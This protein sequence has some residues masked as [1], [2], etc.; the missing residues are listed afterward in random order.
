MNLQQLYFFKE[1]AETRHFTQAAQNLY[2]VQSTLS[3]AIQDLERELGAPL[4][5]RNANKRIELSTY[6][7]AFL[8]YVNQAIS[9]IEEGTDTVKEMLNPRSGVVKIGFSFLNGFALLPKVVNELYEEIDQNEISI[10]IITNTSTLR[11]ESR[12][13]R[14][15]FDLAITCHGGN[16]E[17]ES[18]FIAAQRLM[19]FLPRSHPL[20]KE[21]RVHLSQVSRDTLIGY[22][23]DIIDVWSERVFRESG[24]NTSINSYAP[25]WSALIA[26]V[27]MGMG[28]CLLPNVPHDE[29]YVVAVEID[30]PDPARYLSLSWPKNRKLNGAT[31]YVKDFILDYCSQQQKQ[32]GGKFWI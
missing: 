7:E 15:D 10:Q 4:F 21:K 19:L 3:H 20:A 26:Y 24:V 1:A 11:S 9:S 22:R 8:K 31:E 18:E 12:L 23:S 6:G 5:I 32:N 17:V 2:V 30:H 16:Y 14:G 29:N 13:L 27:S 28:I 25:D